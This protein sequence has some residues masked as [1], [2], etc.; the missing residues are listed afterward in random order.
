L[1]SAIAALRFSRLHGLPQCDFGPLLA[2]V[3]VAG[4]CMEQSVT[5]ADTRVWP[6]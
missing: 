3:R 1:V 4:Y 2:K 5:T 6:M